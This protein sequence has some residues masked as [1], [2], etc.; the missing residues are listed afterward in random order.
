MEQP[1]PPPYDG[2][3]DYDK[4][5]IVQPIILTLIG[6]LIRSESISSPVLYYE[7][8]HDVNFLSR[9]DHKVVFSRNEQRVRTDRHG[10]VRTNSHLKHIFNLESPH[11]ITSTSSYEYFITSVSRRTMGNAGLKKTFVPRPGFKVMQINRSGGDKELFEITRK[12]GIY[13]WWDDEGKRIAIDERENGQLKMIITT[14]MPRPKVDV[15][16]PTTIKLSTLAASRPMSPMSLVDA[17]PMRC[18]NTT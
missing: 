12:N 14:A 15:R 18:P 9:D 4:N 5:D 16:T 17:H 10:T 3:Q 13:E 11:A 8:D 7:L 1:D 6:R 2:L